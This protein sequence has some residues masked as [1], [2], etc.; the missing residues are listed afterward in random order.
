[1]SKMFL[2]VFKRRAY[3]FFTCL[4]YTSRCVKDTDENFP[5]ATKGKVASILVS[6]TDFSGVIR[7]AGHLQNDIKNVTGIL[8]N[9]LNTLSQVDDYIVI[10]GTMGKSS[11]I[12]SL[13]H[14]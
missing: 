7:V 10:V 3:I 11:I 9:V 5:L 13:I 12:L 8:P 4:L 1:M 2:L 14:I 6:E